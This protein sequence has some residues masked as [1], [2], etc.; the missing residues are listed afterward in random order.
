MI[1][2]NAA[3][4]EKLVHKVDV[5]L[6]EDHIKSSKAEWKLSLLIGRLTW[7]WLRTII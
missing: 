4:F 1:T 6:V 3:Y 2:E 5:L 7:I